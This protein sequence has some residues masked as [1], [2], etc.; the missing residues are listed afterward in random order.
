MNVFLRA[1]KSFFHVPKDFWKRM[2]DVTFGV[3]IGLGLTADVLLA[4]SID[5]KEAGVTLWV[6][7]AVGAVIILL[8]LIPAFILFTSFIASA[9][10][11]I[12]VKK[13]AEDGALQDT[14]SV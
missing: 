10:Q 11:S 4:R 13:E 1:I 6:F 7:L 12:K 3:L 8:Q 5:M 2:R 14:E 9:H